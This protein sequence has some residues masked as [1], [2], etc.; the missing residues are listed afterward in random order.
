METTTHNSSDVPHI[1]LTSLGKNAFSTT[2]EWGPKT[3]TA[4]LAPL[5]L[6]EFFQKLSIPMPDHVV[7]VVTKESVV[8]QSQSF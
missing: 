8:F 4:E 6:V 2:Y 1:L 5:A 7:A 3:A